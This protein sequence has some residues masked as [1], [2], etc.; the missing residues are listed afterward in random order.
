MKDEKKVCSLVGEREG[1]LFGDA[2]E[3]ILATMGTDG[4]PYA[5]PMSFV[6]YDNKIYMHCALTGKK[7]DNIKANPKVC[8]EAHETKGLSYSETHTAC[9]TGIAYAG[10]V[11]LGYINFVEDYERKEQILSKIVEKYTPEFSQMPIPSEQIDKTCILEVE[12][13]ECTGKHRI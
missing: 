6:Y 11:I 10:V 7:I 3:C 5:I 13:I 9:S 4:F 1:R 8:I 12:I 2:D